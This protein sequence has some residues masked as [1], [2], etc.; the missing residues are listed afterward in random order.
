MPTFVDRVTK[1]ERIYENIKYTS[2]LLQFLFQYHRTAYTVIIS[3][4]PYLLLFLKYSPIVMCTYANHYICKQWMTILMVELKLNFKR[5]VTLPICQLTCKY[6]YIRLK[7]CKTHKIHREAYDTRAVAFNEFTQA[8]ISQEH[9]LFP[10]GSKKESGLAIT[11]LLQLN[12]ENIFHFLNNSMHLCIRS[13][14][15]IVRTMMTSPN[16]NI[17]CVTGTF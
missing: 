3:V 5:S 2:L 16:V 6:K 17:F 13:L 1:G 7:K 12:S 9:T 14:V 15:Q 4:T 11:S 10:Q 8:M